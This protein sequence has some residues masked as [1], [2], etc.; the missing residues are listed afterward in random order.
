MREITN[1]VRLVG[2]LGADV[3]VRDFDGGK[4][5]AQMRLATN[6][7]FKGKNGEWQDKTYWHT[8]VAWDK[9]AD[10]MSSKLTKG[11]RILV[12]GRLGYSEYIDSSDI[13]RSRAE[14]VVRKFKNLTA[15]KEGP[16]PF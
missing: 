9:L 11:S 16:T 5:V 6:E 7:P 4:K 15:K 13:K 2:H 10:I 1:N 12:E 8:L 14:I 3:D